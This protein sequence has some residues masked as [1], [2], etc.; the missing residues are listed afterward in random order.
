MSLSARREYLIDGRYQRAGRPHPRRILDE[1]WV[2]CA[3]RALTRRRA[4]K[5]PG[6][7]APRSA[8]VS[9]TRVLAPPVPARGG[10]PRYL[11]IPK[12]LVEAP[13]ARSALRLVPPD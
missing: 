3:P 6:H 4:A 13:G 11:A 1:S 8:W 9:P 7:S 5:T 10:P 12:R 2:T